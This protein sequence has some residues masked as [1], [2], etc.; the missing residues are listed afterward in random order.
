MFTCAVMTSTGSVHVH[1]P[2][3]T[4]PIPWHKG[5]VSGDECHPLEPIPCSKRHGKGMAVIPWALIPC[6]RGHWQPG[7][8]G[9]RALAQGMGPLKVAPCLRGWPADARPLPRGRPGCCRYGRECE[10]PQ[11]RFAFCC[12]LASHRHLHGFV[13][14]FIYEFVCW[15]L[16]IIFCACAVRFS[17]RKSQMLFQMCTR[18][19]C[20]ARTSHR[21]ENGAIDD[22]INIL[23]CSVSMAS[24]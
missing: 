9:P 12:V 24:P 11:R 7:D 6:V 1:Q 18:T 5:S 19:S 15:W 8:G 23:P 16:L 4:Q 17:P 10:S 14:H 3:R 21:C 2:V 22:A 20:C 13:S